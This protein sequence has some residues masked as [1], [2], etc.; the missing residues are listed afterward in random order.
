MALE[1]ENYMSYCFN[2]GIVPTLGLFATWLGVNLAEFE[3]KVA[4]YRSTRPSTADQLEV[5][6][7]VLRGFVE[8]KALDGDIAPALYLH[9]NKAYYDA[10]ENAPVQKS[11]EMEAHVRD[12]SQLAEL[13]ELLPEEVKTVDKG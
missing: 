13:I 12:E 5:C 6:K 8:T 4:H 2:F 7:E 1:F 9:Q 11:K 3:K 10:V